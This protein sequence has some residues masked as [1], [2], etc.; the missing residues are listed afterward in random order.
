MAKTKQFLHTPLGLFLVG[1]LSLGL[2]YLVFLRAVD[3]GSLQQY[4]VMLLL[5][6]FG[7][8]RFVRVIR[9]LRK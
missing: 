2:A 4:F 6:F 5:I 9:V 1:V 3:T 7:L 8:N